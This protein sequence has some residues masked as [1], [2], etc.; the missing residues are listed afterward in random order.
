MVLYPANSFLSFP[1]YLFFSLKAEKSL[2]YEP[3]HCWASWC[4][5]HGLRGENILAAVPD[6]VAT[7]T[8]DGPEK[9]ENIVVMW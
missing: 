4:S 2:V 5:L 7:L 6:Q 8:S 3:G 9:S 1:V